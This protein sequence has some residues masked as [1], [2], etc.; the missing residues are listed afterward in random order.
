MSV[1]GRKGGFM[2]ETLSHQ[3]V[4]ISYN[5]IYIYI[6]TYIYIYIYT[7]IYILMRSR[8]VN[9]NKKLQPCSWSLGGLTTSSSSNQRRHTQGRE[10]SRTSTLML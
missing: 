9:E 10:K 1:R 7:D 2:V 4:E 8:M 3:N 5:Y 6:H